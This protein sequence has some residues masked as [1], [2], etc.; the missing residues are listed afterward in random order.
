MGQVTSCQDRKGYYSEMDWA[1]Q[2]VARLWKGIR[3]VCTAQV[4][5]TACCF[6]DE[7]EAHTD[8]VRS[9]RNKVWRLIKKKKGG[10]NDGGVAID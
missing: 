10:D 5:S 7:A 4:K 1:G 2:S 9:R 6:R 8:R 3:A